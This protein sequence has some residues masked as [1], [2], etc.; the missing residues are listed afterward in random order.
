MACLW[1]YNRKGFLVWCRVAFWK[2]SDT[3]VFNQSECITAA[4]MSALLYVGCKNLSTLQTY[5]NYQE[6]IHAWWVTY[7][8]NPSICKYHK[9]SNIS[10]GLIDIF[11]HILGS[12]Y[13]QGLIFGGLIF[14]GHF[15]LVFAYSKLWNLLSY[16]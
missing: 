1:K 6:H 8:K 14:G 11:K 10:P 2:N 12:L 13:S 7:A 4:F 15:V 16:Q 9:I 3:G 5:F